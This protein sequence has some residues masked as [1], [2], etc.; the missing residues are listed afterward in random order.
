MKKLENFMREHRDD[1]DS[2]LPSLDMWDKIET[3]LE[4]KKG[5]KISL[6]KVSVAVAAVLV[7]AVIGTFMLN[8]KTSYNKY[9]NVSDP[10]LREL[11]ETEAF[12]A[13]KVSYQMNEINKCYQVFPELKNDIETDLDELNSMYKELENDLNDNFY[14]REVIE[15]MIQ[16]NRL[17]LEMV[18]RV[19]NQINC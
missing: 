17:K 16:N 12:Y 13:R 8:T 9:A 14:N 1:F 7:L 18:D 3:E 15:A 19:L 11:L 10:E 6:W 4:K 2:K 5:R